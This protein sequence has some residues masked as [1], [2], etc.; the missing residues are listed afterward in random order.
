MGQGDTQSR[1]IHHRAERYTEQRGTPQGREIHI[2]RYTI[3]QR[4]THRAE[5]YR[6]NGREAN[7]K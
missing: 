6:V 5:R 2:E 1:E 4:D 3:G 7:R